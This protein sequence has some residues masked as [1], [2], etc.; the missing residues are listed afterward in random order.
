MVTAVNNDITLNTAIPGLERT[1]CDITKK[2]NKK[3]FST[4]KKFSLFSLMYETQ[5]G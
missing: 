5:H 1:N 2:G 4:W 3:S